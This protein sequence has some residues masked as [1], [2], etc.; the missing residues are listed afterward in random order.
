MKKLSQA[1]PSALGYIQNT[2]IPGRRGDVARI[3]REHEDI[4]LSPYTWALATRALGLDMRTSPSRSEVAV[5][6]VIRL[7]LCALRSS[8]AGV[9]WSPTRDARVPLMSFLARGGLSEATFKRRLIALQRAEDLGEVARLLETMV[10][11]ASR[12]QQPYLVD[13]V[14][15]AYDFQEWLNIE[16]RGAVRSRWIQ[17]AIAGSL[18]LD[19][20]M[21]N[22]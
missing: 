5:G 10:R 22:E 17:Q 16:G 20:P 15:L 14:S 9:V 8:G 3:A 12:N 21:E 7:A 2:S 6:H 4:G 19:G 18:V 11:S 13:W 1:V